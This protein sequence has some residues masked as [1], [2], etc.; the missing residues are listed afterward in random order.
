MF[1]SQRALPPVAIT[2]ATTLPVRQFLTSGGATQTVSD[3]GAFRELFL[4]ALRGEERADAN[5][6]GYLT[7]SEIGLFLSDRMTNLT[8][9]RQTPRYG[10]LRDKDYD[11]G[12]FVFALAAPAPVRGAAAPPP[13]TGPAADKETVF[14]QSIEDSTDAADF[15]A[16]LSRFAGGTFAGLARNRLVTLNNRHAAAPAALLKASPVP[17]PPARRP[18]SI[19]PSDARGLSFSMIVASG[20][21]ADSLE[22]LPKNAKVCGL[23]KKVLDYYRTQGDE[24]PRIV[25]VPADDLPAAFRAQVCDVLVQRGDRLEGAVNALE[26][27]GA[28]GYRTVPI[29]L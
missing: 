28:T 9:T 2:R 1:D 23:S 18:A 24:A 14:W 8:V 6:D 19:R 10:K 20:I 25:R 22:G 27:A 3:D 15:K 29:D 7:A 17:P 16:Y 26:A 13:G 4:R 5:R 12:D 11:L 21:Q